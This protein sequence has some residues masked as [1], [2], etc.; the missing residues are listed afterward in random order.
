MFDSVALGLHWPSSDQKEAS[1]LETTV[2][3]AL[4]LYRQQNL[5]SPIYFEQGVARRRLRCELSGL[6]W[7]TGRANK[8]T[9]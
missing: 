8:L 2:I 1:L 5:I 6:C 9:Q 4:V 7:A 3:Q